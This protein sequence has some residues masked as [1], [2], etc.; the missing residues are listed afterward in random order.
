MTLR[1]FLAIEESERFHELM[2]GE[3]FQKALP[4]GE[5]GGAQSSIV[6]AL[7]PRYQRRVGGPGGPGGWWFATEVEL[8]LGESDVVRP[9]VLG[10]RRE[11][12]PARPTG[13]PVRIRPDWFCEIVSPS[14]ANVDTVRKLRRYHEAAIPYYWIVDPRDETLTVFRWAEPGYLAVLRAERGETVHAEPFGELALPVGTLFGDD[15][16]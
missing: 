12:S 6:G 8:L 13:A 4:T 14:N 9:D 3:L 2:S 11:T 7:V 1:D 10:W 16:D 5:H 15:V